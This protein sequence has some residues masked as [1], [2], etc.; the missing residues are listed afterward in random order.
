M[1]FLLIFCRFW[2]SG[3]LCAAFGGV[4]RDWE[5]GGAWSLLSHFVR[6]PHRVSLPLLDLRD[7]DRVRGLTEVGVA[8]DGKCHSLIKPG[9]WIF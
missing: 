3:R 7:D 8:C 2:D 5:H 1:G 9:S 4:A 6:P